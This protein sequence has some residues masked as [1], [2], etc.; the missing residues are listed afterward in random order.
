MAVVRVRGLGGVASRASGRRWTC[1]W[2]TATGGSQRAC[3]VTETRKQR[4]ACQTVRN[5]A[6]AE[7]TGLPLD[8]EPPRA[9][10]F[11]VRRART[12][13]CKLPC[14]RGLGVVFSAAPALLSERVVISPG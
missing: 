13:P 7:R 6:L 2:P 11:A 8:L 12:F 1:L 4:H 5:P 10:S 3:H 14:L 9:L